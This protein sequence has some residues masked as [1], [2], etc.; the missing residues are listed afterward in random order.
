VGFVT[1]WVPY[2][3]LKGHW[4]DIIILNVHSPAEDESDFAKDISC[5]ELEHMFDQFP[6]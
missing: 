2:A 5:K 4:C 3:V 1:D 6:E